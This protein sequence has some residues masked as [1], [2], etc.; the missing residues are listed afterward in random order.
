MIVE[1]RVYAP[2]RR[3]RPRVAWALAAVSLTPAIAG[4]ELV[5]AGDPDMMYVKIRNT[6]DVALYIAGDSTVRDL[7]GVGF[8]PEYDM[9]PPGTVSGIS[10]INTHLSSETLYLWAEPEG[11]D[12]FGEPRG[13]VPQSEIP[14]ITHNDGTTDRIIDFPP[15]LCPVA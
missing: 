2:M 5:V 15:D 3:A 11:S 8:P 10:R 13:S 7:Q 9:V 4:C 6:C 1:R 14:V 12:H